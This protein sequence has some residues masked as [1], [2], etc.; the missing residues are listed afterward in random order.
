MIIRFQ[1]DKHSVYYEHRPADFFGAAFC[2]ALIGFALSK[3][4]LRE[5]T[6]DALRTGIRSA[7]AGGLYT[8]SPYFTLGLIFGFAAVE[9]GRNLAERH[10]R[11]I[12]RTMIVD[13]DLARQFRAALL[14]EGPE[15]RKLWRLAHTECVLETSAEDA[16]AI[17][18]GEVL[19][20][21]PEDLLDCGRAGLLAIPDVPEFRLAE[22][23][24]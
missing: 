12:R 21:D 10:A 11:E 4:L 9:F 23:A 24:S 17:P 13:A 15:V 3:G 16:L 8:V 6:Q 2:S 19:P 7:L 22:S 20:S 18:D 1:A 5:K 14:E